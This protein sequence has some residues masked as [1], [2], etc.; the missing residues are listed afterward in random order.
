MNRH[1]TLETLR[2]ARKINVT[3]NLIAP[4]GEA[5]S[6]TV[7]QYAKMEGMGYTEFRTGQAAD[8]GDLTGLPEFEMISRLDKEGNKVGEYKVTSFVLPAWFPREENTVVFFDEVNRGAKDILN[9]IFEAILDLS[10][11]N[12][13][14]PKGCQ[15]V[16]A[17]NPPTSDYSGTLDFDDK[18]WL[19]RFVHIRFQP[20]HKEFMEFYR[21]KFGNSGFVEFLADQDGMIRAKTES[22]EVGSLVTPS[23]RSWE[24]AL[25]LEQMW[26]NGEITD[27]GVFNEILFGTI[28]STATL[29]AN[30]FK[31]THIRSIKGKDLIESYHTAPVRESVLMAIKK[32]RTDMLGLALQ[33]IDAEFKARKGLSEVE[34]RNVIDLTKDLSK[35]SEHQYTLFRMITQN[36]A[37]TGNCAGFELSPEHTG[38]GLSYAKEILDLATKVNKV[39]NEA[40]AEMEKVKTKKSKKVK[41]EEVPF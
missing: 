9:G 26:D 30:T 18:A 39:R 14:M 37:C 3:V 10:M 2:I 11:K 29:A 12:I 19:D 25:K 5:K 16:C 1:N 41:A 21:S 6:S 32:G 17:M 35:A 33:E 7:K 40:N 20:T 34:A 24:T 4:H 8:A 38:A 15:I 13:P 27:E 28:G 31:K 22:F 36:H 23:P